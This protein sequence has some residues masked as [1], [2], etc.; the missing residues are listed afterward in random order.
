MGTRIYTD[1]AC[2]GN[3]G[4]GGWAWAIEDGP[5]ASGYDEQ[6]TNQR[7]EVT[8]AFEAVLANEGPIEI[9]SDSTYVVNCFRDSWYV[10]WRTRGWL[11]SQKKPVANRD[12]WE[13]FIERVLERG[14]VTFSWVKGHS[15]DP[16]ND[17]VDRLAVG[18]VLDKAGSS[19]VGRPSELPPPDLPPAKT[20]V[21][22]GGP[23]LPDGH[24]VLVTG[25]RPPE[26][27]GYDPNLRWEAAR[28][29]ITEALTYLLT[30]HD[31]LLVV[32]GMG[33]G[34]EQ[35]AAEAAIDAGVPF[36]AAPAHPDF[37]RVWPKESRDRYRALTDKAIAEVVFDDRTP[38]SKQ[39]AGGMAARR[40]AW[41][42]R[43]VAEAIVVHDGE[44][45]RTE[46]TIASLVLQL[47]DDNV[48][49]LLP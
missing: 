38:T 16:M 46:K 17:L 12:L 49:L 44:D 45:E 31:D 47:G 21:A 11:N 27:G 9:V 40:D 43:N 22:G 2:S 1:G 13:P 8:A 20:K 35:L 26:L 37:D 25:L 10:G 14:D 41:L 30:E 6:T 36:V 29:V 19:G 5:W 15:T 32:T 7:M 3:P 23:P 4:P 34:T 42:A 24:R 18:A 33:L 48:L 28:G 39:Q